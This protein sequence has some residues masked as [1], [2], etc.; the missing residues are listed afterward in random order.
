[1][2]DEKECLECNARFSISTLIRGTKANAYGDKIKYGY[3]CKKCYRKRVTRRSSILLGFCVGLI[4]FTLISFSLS[5][6]IYLFVTDLLAEE[7]FNT[8]ETL[9]LL[10]LIFATFSIIIYYIRYRE[11]NNMR[12]KIRSLRS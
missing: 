9:N 5:I 2:S 3:I 1:M 10:G 8:I 12:E 6:Y 11:L 7:F 4:I